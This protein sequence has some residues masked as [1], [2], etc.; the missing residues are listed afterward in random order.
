MVILTKL[1]DWLRRKGVSEL[2]LGVAEAD[3]KKDHQDCHVA[4]I[5]APLMD[6]DASHG[7]MFNDPHRN[8]VAI[9]D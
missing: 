7:S 6:F 3:D 4:L 8:G 9:V 2:S 5:E 1:Y